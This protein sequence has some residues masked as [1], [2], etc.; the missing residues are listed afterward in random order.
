MHNELNP[1]SNGRLCTKVNSV[2]SRCVDVC[3]LV[4]L[5]DWR[6]IKL[7]LIFACV[8]W[9]NVWF[10]YL[11]QFHLWIAKD[12]A[13]IE[14]NP[15]QMKHFVLRSVLYIVDLQSSVCPCRLVCVLTVGIY[16]SVCSCTHDNYNQGAE[17]ENELNQRSNGTFWTKV[18][19]NTLNQGQMNTLNHGQFCT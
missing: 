4:V 15:S 17:W 8:E 13:D 5:R 1:R 3:I 16:S 18:K 7:L 2:H 11:L 19:C 14:L 6:Q 10:S 12:M 9:E